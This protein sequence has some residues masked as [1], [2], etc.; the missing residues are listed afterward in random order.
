[1]DAFYFPLE[2]PI[3]M[4]NKAMVGYFLPNLR[5]KQQENKSTRIK[6]YGLLHIILLLRLMRQDCWLV[7][8]LGQ[9]ERCHG[10]I[11]AQRFCFCCLMHDV[12]A[13]NSLAKRSYNVEFGEKLVVPFFSLYE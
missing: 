4:V 2:N 8:V 5:K 9:T 3:V 1:L 11:D 6:L 7:V 13:M 12:K 10:W